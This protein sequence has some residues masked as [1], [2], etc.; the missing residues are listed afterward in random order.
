MSLRARGERAANPERS[1]KGAVIIPTLIATLL[2]AALAVGGSV[3]LVQSQS[4]PNVAPVRQPL[5]DYDQ[6]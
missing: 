2:G 4:N 1:E 5:I 3:A 6:R